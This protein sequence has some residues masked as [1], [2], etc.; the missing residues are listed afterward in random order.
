MAAA[1][2]TLVRTEEPPIVF[3]S[4]SHKDEKWKDALLP[5]LQ[6]LD[7]LG[8]LSVWDDRQIK[9]GVE[10]YKRIH[11]TLQKTKVAVCLIS[12]D[13]LA[14]S[15]CMDEE[16]AYLLQARNRG[17]L[18]IFPILI[19][20]CIW[21]EHP[22]LK[23]LQMLPRDAQPLDAPEGS[24]ADRE[25][26]ELARQV[27]DFLSSGKGWEPPKVDDPKV[28]V[29]IDRLP[30][31]GELLFGRREELK[32][33]DDTWNDNTLN[34]A[35]FKASGGVGK[36]SLVRAWVEDMALDN[37]RGA[38]RVF[39]WSFY[40]QGTQ[41]RVTSADELISEALGWFG[42]E[43]KG[44]G[45][46]P[47]DRGQ[48][49]ADLVREKRTL[50]LLDG[51]EPLQSGQVFDRGKIKD[52]GLEVLLDE[53][54]RNN[55]GLCLI[56]T[57]EEVSDLWHNLDQSQVEQYDLDTISTT[58]G[59]AL[60]RVSGIEGKDAALE[61]AVKDYGQ[62]AYA[63]KLLGS[64]LTWS[65]T[66][67]IKHAANIPDLPDV[68]ENEGKHP[69][70]VM[71]AFAERFGDSVK[72]DI[73][74]MLGLFDRPADAGCIDALRKEPVIPGLNAAVMQISE[75][76]WQE[77][78]DGLRRIGLLTPESHH[79]S[80]ELDAHPLV[81]EHFGGRQRNEREG[82][83]KAGHE[84]L[85]EHL[86]T[87]PEMHQP[88]TLAGMAPL[89]QAVHHG[90]QA[91]RQDASFSIYWDRINRGED[92]YSAIT[93]GAHSTE[94]SLL[95]SIL[96][97]ASRKTQ[98]GITK[99]HLAEVLYRFAFSYQALG[100]LSEAA[101]RMR[102][103]LRRFLQLEDWSGASEVAAN[104][105]LLMSN[106]GDLAES[107]N[108][109][110]EAMIYADRSNIDHW[111]AC[112]LVQFGYVMHQIGQ[113]EKALDL[114]E[115][116]ESI[117]ANLRPI[118]IGGRLGNI[119]WYCDLLLAVNRLDLA[120]N[121][122]AQGSQLMSS[123]AHRGPS[124]KAFLSL[125]KGRVS[126]IVGENGEAKMLLNEAVDG[127]RSAGIVGLL[128]FSLLARAAFFREIEE[129]EKSRHDLDEVMRLATRCGMRLHECDAHLELSRLE[130]KQGQLDAARL[131]LKP[132][133]AL[134]NAC[135]YHRRDKEV[136]DLKEELGL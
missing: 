91:G 52:P 115:K 44:E 43:S 79:A 22:W 85:Y 48:H 130:I 25:F 53:L 9:A 76:V 127:H 18:E 26:A 94:V 19:R 39:A 64:F 32:F 60:L 4:Y 118:D 67:D 27:R 87:V 93:L 110:E 89:F 97:V 42:D 73:L 78:I 21:D 104:L 17:D 95:N 106:L 7:R 1:L 84:R 132:A 46:S 23:R 31:T 20:H 10:W 134:V 51:L 68:E 37:Y 135:G 108:I 47:W 70:R 40:S 11:E 107:R 105:A 36:S 114:F 80:C 112:I 120:R 5:Q 136:A 83:W 129:Y 62:H 16:I 28:D 34:V 126:M 111:K 103:A 12:P 45:K 57:R 96:G 14:S 33:L 63:V 92:R 65:G 58:A 98:I 82:A 75:T 29:D 90:C 109:A 133:E 124:A 24:N 50:L 86:R 100:N 71:A 125:S 74:A 54:G 117:D 81:R 101:D 99:R 119:Y 72:S 69:R 128:P 116:S 56:S 77:Q 15:F 59:R 41:E 30:Q 6:N 88:D 13:F 113:Y 49:L 8:I 61:Q 121:L 35:V 55:P 2:R 122:T 3:V 131:H 102:F 123:G 38:A 66:P